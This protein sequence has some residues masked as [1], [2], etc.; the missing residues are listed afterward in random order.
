MQTAALRREA[1]AHEPGLFISLRCSPALAFVH[2]LFRTPGNQSKHLL[3]TVVDIHYIGTVPPNR[4]FIAPSWCRRPPR[5][6]VLCGQVSAGIKEPVPI[7]LKRFAESCRITEQL[8][9]I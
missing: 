4:S 8:S 1:F 2:D 9:P 6:R 7:G 5:T 3:G